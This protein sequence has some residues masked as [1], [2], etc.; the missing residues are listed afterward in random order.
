MTPIH[1]LFSAKSAQDA[2]FAITVDKTNVKSLKSSDVGKVSSAPTV[3]GMILN[4]WNESSL[5]MFDSSRCSDHQVDKWYR[6]QRLSVASPWRQSIVQH[7]HLYYL[8][9]FRGQD[10]GLRRWNLGLLWHYRWLCVCTSMWS[11]SSILWQNAVTHKSRSKKSNQS[12]LWT[13]PL[14]FAGKVVFT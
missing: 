5:L 14:D 9:R 12:F 13:P 1:M 2:P 8:Q 6:V 4:R 10:D 7:R 3:T 11:R